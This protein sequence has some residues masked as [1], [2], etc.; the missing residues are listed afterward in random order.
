MGSKVTPENREITEYKYNGLFKLLAVFTMPLE[1]IFFFG[2]VMGWPNA[3]EL[4]K[5]LG[6]YADLCQTNN[7]TNVSTTDSFLVN[8]S[9]RDELF[10]FGF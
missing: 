7:T 5:K 4:Y 3:V 10:S 6:V 1:G 2:T 8:C 9:E